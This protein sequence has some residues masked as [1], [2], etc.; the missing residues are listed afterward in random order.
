[1]RP[2]LKV[3]ISML[4][5]GS[6]GLFVSVIPYDSQ[7]IA[8]SRAAIGFVVLMIARAF[9]KE[10][11]PKGDYLKALPL[12]LFIGGIM[13]LN[14]GLLFSA[15]KMCGVS[16][17]TLIYYLAPIITIVL[18][19]IFL[20]E[21][22]TPVKIA[23][24]AMALLGMVMINGGGNVSGTNVVLGMI[25]ALIAASFYGVIVFVN[26]ASKSIAK[27]NS[28]EYTITEMFAAALTSGA[29]AA[30]TGGFQLEAPTPICIASLLILGLVHT[31]LAYLLY[32]GSIPKLPGH[33]LAVLSYF[34][35]VSALFLSAI[36]LS[37]R[38][39]FLQ[40]VGAVLVLGGAAVSQLIKTKNSQDA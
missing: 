6:L 8:F 10:R 12:M 20:K 2:E 15:Y 29:Y 37:E 40:W 17:A 3:I 4:I 19:A 35:P 30:A 23:G 13:G 27:V 24:I 11:T 34:D 25:F 31:G 7:F 22:L 9:T 32:F 5:W 33:T 39:S 21:K 38:M 28:L 18:C 26:K 16:V 1:M 14:W 36:F